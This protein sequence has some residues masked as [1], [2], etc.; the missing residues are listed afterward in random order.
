MNSLYH[1]KIIDSLFY[2]ARTTPD[3]IAIIIA[4]EDR[5]ITYRELKEYVLGVSSYLKSLDLGQNIIVSC[6]RK[7]LSWIALYLACNMC[8][9]TIGVIDPKVSRSNL[10]AILLQTKSNILYGFDLDGYTSLKFKLHPARSIEIE[11][12]QKINGECVA[13]VMFTSGTTG[14]PKGAC[15]SYYNINASVN[16]INHHIKISDSDVELIGLPICHS[17]GLGR[18]RCVIDKGATA[19]LLPNFSNVKLFFLCIEKYKVTGFGIVPAAWLYIQHFSGQYISRFSG[20]IKYVE[21]GSAALP[22]EEKLKLKELLPDTAIIMHYGLTEASRSFFLDFNDGSCDLNSVGHPS[23][24]IM[25]MIM[26]DNNDICKDN[27]LGEI[28]VKGDTVIKSYLDENDNKNCFINGYFRTGD[29]GYKV[30]N[31]YYLEGRFKEL[32]NVGGKK[33][34]PAEVEAAIIKLG[35]KEC[36]CVG[37]KDPHGILGEIPK[38]FM[39]KGDEDISIKQITEALSKTLEPYK[40]P[41]EFVWINSIPKTESGK[42]K[43]TE[44]KNKT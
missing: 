14:R 2:H 37:F 26:N 43:R 31:T 24:F 3:K 35:I 44:L 34:N 7:D 10:D 41:R 11:C 1:S 39:V 19:V 40:I 12:G 33:V 8:G 16:N 21:I 17:F 38:V 27:E 29:C 18:L 5:Y 20:Q 30:G 28:C 6:A 9:I 32:I 36:A 15:L 23:Q 4:N 22:I 25:P 13:E 42:I